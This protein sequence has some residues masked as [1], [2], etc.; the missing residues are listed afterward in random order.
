MVD[1]QGLNT[2]KV[3]AKAMVQAAGG[4]WRPLKDLLAMQQAAAKYAEQ[5]APGGPPTVLPLIPPPPRGEKLRPPTARSQPD[6]VPAPVIDEPSPFPILAEPASV[7]LEVAVPEPVIDEG[8]SL[9]EG[10][11]ISPTDFSEDASASPL[12][13]ALSTAEPPALAF[14]E[15]EPEAWA[16][17]P[18]ILAGDATS[19]PSTTAAEDG[20]ATDDEMVS[21][22]E[23]EP[24]SE[25]DAWDPE[26][27]QWQDA[28]EAPAIS[29]RGGVQSLADDPT[30]RFQHAGEVPTY[31]AASAKHSPAPSDHR[32]TYT[33]M[34]PGFEED[35]D[36]FKPRTIVIDERL[37][38]AANVFGTFLSRTLDFLVGAYE[39][40][41][42]ALSDWG[43]A[44]AAR[45]A[46]APPPPS[47]IT[48]LRL[49]TD[50]PPPVVEEAPVVPE[51]AP[52]Q[53]IAEDPSWS[54]DEDEPQRPTVAEEVPVSALKPLDDEA[55]T[56]LDVGKH[57]DRLGDTVSAWAQAIRE[58]VE[59]LRP[60]F[61][62][63]PPPPPSEAEAPH[64]SYEAPR[65]PV[66]PPP[67]V[68]ELPVLRLAKIEEPEEP[69]DVYEE[70]ASESR[71]PA[72]WPWMKRIAWTAVLVAGGFAAYQGWES[73]YPK[74][75]DLSSAAF[76]EVSR[77]AQTREQRERQRRALK[78]ST[79]QLPHL[80]P[81]TIQLVLNQSPNVVPDP[82]EVFQ[83]ASNAVD[84]G[85]S[86]LSP[87][88][89]QE[90]KT[91]NREVLRALSP[92]ERARVRE[93]DDVRA[94]RMPFAFEDKTALDLYAR[95][96]RTLPE[97][98][99]ERLQALVG[100][101][102]ASGL[103]SP[104]VDPAPKQPN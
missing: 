99:R 51:A 5:E 36:L 50:E 66:V 45:R 88:E 92:A 11:P 38:S 44:R 29:A 42:Q 7:N 94:R 41:R 84:R 43:A 16:D 89:R 95:G 58:R 1:Q 72:V 68:S 57:I 24:T 27:S 98:S 82:P 101:A 32:P 20:T 53:V 77:Y 48:A 74:A 47:P 79:E 90:L 28:V 9:D 19:P 65:K 26:P 102:V 18:A 86:A 85:V 52:T 6:P 33:P 14:V 40:V 73:W 31:G 67:P 23:T 78:E 87:E 3:D 70:T 22:P 54:R 46:A 55:P 81:H 49:E 13:D 100:K 75:T 63:P 83:A 35:D 15:P 4:R 80:A 71:F 61:E 37:V 12:P 96:A 97:E 64:I 8:P 10:P 103:T 62:A 93:Y 59:D 56:G 69:Q 60:S 21:F 39:R 2:W 25:A 104:T 76:T 17:E 34:E 30:A 91:L